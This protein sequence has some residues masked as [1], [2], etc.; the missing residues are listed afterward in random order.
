VTAYEKTEDLLLILRQHLVR[1]VNTS[2]AICSR[3]VSVS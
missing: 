2:F 1:N 3:S